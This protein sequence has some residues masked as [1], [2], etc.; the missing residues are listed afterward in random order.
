MENRH[1]IELIEIV[2]D[3]VG[4]V[5]TICDKIPEADPERRHIE[6]V[7]DKRLSDLRSVVYKEVNP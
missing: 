6:R 3:L 4:E 1:L 2:Q 7:I 5:K